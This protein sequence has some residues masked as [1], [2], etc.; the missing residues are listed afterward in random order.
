MCADYVSVKIL[1]T[2]IPV[3][4]LSGKDDDCCANIADT[5]Y[6]QTQL[7]PADFLVNYLQSG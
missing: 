6:L 1:Q 5:D 2:A 7:L 3:K 4:I